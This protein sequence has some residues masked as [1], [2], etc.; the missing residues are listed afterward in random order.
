MQQ[1]H[2]SPKS[3]Q[4]IG[5]VLFLVVFVVALSVF[6]VICLPTAAKAQVSISLG[7]QEMYDDNV[8]LEDGQRRPA[9]VILDDQFE[10][11]FNDGE[12]PT[13]LSDELDGE[14]SDDL[15]TNLNLSLAGSS[16]Y[17]RK[18]L[19]NRFQLGVGAILFA[20]YNN[21]NRLTLDGVIDTS[22]AKTWLPDPFYASIA[23]EFRS[24]ASDNVSFAE[25][26]A[27]RASQIYVLSG[28]LGLANV[29]LARHLSWGLGYT[30]TYQIFLGELRFEDAAPGEFEEEGSDFHS[31]SLGTNVDYA[32][33]PSWTFGIRGEAGVQLFTNVETNDIDSGVR[34]EDDLDRNNY[35]GRATL[36]Y[37]PNREFQFS[38]FAGLNRSDFRKSPEPFEVTVIDDNGETMT[39]LVERDDSETNFIY[40]ADV[41]YSFAPGTQVIV[42]VEQGVGTDID[43]DRVT[44]RS[45][46]SNGVL[47]IT[48]RLSFTVGARYLEYSST[49]DL[50]NAVDRLEL[51]SSL[52]F[53]VTQQASIVL[54][55]NFV[56]QNSDDPLSEDLLFTR[57]EEYTVNRVYIGVNVGILGLPG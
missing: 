14:E 19:E 33:S 8:F 1:V 34:T 18:Y 5:P 7:V 45:V 26:T 4:P 2:V 36:R 53:L 9:F 47:G 27:S 31:H 51:S 11:D 29:A 38:T 56:D 20:E 23:N 35:D 22:A 15:L 52:S 46:Y 17:F 55:Y 12:V 16:P 49:N 50:D 37:A 25:G 48:D 43:G 6:A 30:G 10:E 13:I 44:T 24:T 32:I 40:G 21:R 3:D 42:G 39:V 57:S 28:R 54:G 41:G